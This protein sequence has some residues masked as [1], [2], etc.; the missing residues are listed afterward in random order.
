METWG[1]GS[2]GRLARLRMPR[3]RSTR[4]SSIQP[5]RS[6]MSAAITCKQRRYRDV[7]CM[8]RS[9]YSD[10][11]SATALYRA[12]LDTHGRPCGVQRGAHRAS[13]HSLPMQPFS[14]PQSVL[15]RL[16]DP[17]TPHQH[18]THRA[19]HVSTASLRQPLEATQW[20]RCQLLSGCRLSRSMVSCTP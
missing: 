7:P 9:R 1:G 6:D 2:M 11:G 8:R 16:E 3:I 5:K 15:D 13:S 20:S 18:T 12:L 10:T 19:H 17:P 4:D 14:V